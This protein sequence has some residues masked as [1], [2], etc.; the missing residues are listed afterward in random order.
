MLRSLPEPLT[1]H[2]AVRSLRHGVSRMRRACR[3]SVGRL[4]QEMRRLHS[5]GHALPL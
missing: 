3:S 5:A 4:R 1:K 2:N